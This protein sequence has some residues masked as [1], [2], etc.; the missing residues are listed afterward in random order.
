M[1]FC[2]VL[3][4]IWAAP[5]GLAAILDD[6]GVPAAGKPQDL[7]HFHPLAMKF[8]SHLLPSDDQLL[9]IALAFLLLLTLLA[10]LLRLFSLCRQLLEWR[11]WAPLVSLAGKDNP[12]APALE[13]GRAALLECGFEWT[14]TRRQRGLLYTACDL[15]EYVEVY[16]QREHDVHALLWPAVAGGMG[17]AA[18]GATWRVQLCNHYIDGSLLLTQWRGS[19]SPQLLPRHAQLVRAPHADVPGLLQ[20]HLA[21]R[22]HMASVRTHPADSLPLA[23]AWGERLLLWLEFEGQVQDC[24]QRAQ[25]KNLYRLSWRA[26]WRL[27]WQSVSARF[28]QRMHSLQHWR[29]PAWRFWRAA[30]ENAGQTLAYQYAQWQVWHLAQA[31]QA[32]DWGV[33]LRWGGAGGLL[34]L[35]LWLGGSPAL[36]AMALP[37]VAYVSAHFLERRW[38]LRHPLGLLLLPLLLPALLIAL[39]LGLV[40]SQVL[41]DWPGEQAALVYW[42]AWAALA[43]AGLQLLPLPGLAGG[44]IVQ[45]ALPSAWLRLGLLLV[46]LAG[47]SLMLLLRQRYWLL[48][49]L[50][51]LS[52][53]LPTAIRKIRAQALLQKQA[54]LESYLPQLARLRLLSNNGRLALLSLLAAHQGQAQ[55]GRSARLLA[56]SL[57]AGLLIVPGVLGAAL[58]L[59]EPMRSVTWWQQSKQFWLQHEVSEVHANEARRHTGRNPQARSKDLNQSTRSPK[60]PAASG[61]Q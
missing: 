46:L 31:R 53:L 13:E 21:R 20:A 54:S 38:Q 15:A 12:L 30:Q 41:L 32:L 5:G 55:A 57:Y 50:A 24:G 27:A 29:L 26:A 28:W 10:P 11:L 17:Q 52:L 49:P 45:R 18:G 60:M 25:G 47:L 37:L 51:V 3:P 58:V 9:L 35:A 39:G 7:L 34:L 42:L 48:L 36:M 56:I 23:R 33:Y 40:Y 2:P 44:R 22:Q 6:T 14:H 59:Q 61:G 8:P 1:R 16:Y 4:L 19:L 43:T